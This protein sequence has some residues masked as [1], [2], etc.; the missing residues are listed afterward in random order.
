LEIQ[1]RHGLCN[2]SQVYPCITPNAD[3]MDFL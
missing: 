3:L 2:I 1:R